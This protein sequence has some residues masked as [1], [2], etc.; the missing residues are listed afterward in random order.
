MLRQ[1]VAAAGARS[2]LRLQLR[3]KSTAQSSVNLQEK[4]VTLCRHRGFVFPGSDIYGGLANSFDYGPLGVQMKKNIQDAWWKHFVQSRTDC[5]GLD[6][7]VILSS[8]VWEASGHIGNFTDPMTVCKGC[9]SR[10]RADKL[11]ENA[12]DV[13]GVK[14]AGGLSCEE[15]DALIAE[16]KI[17]CPTCGSPD[18]QKTRQFNL[19]F[20][21]NMG[22]TDETSEWVYLRPET[23]QGAYINFQHVVTT[24][25]RRLPFGVGQMGKSF[26]NEISPGHYLFRTRE[27]E[28]LELQYF[29]HPTESDTWFSYWV[30]ECFNWL[31]KHGVKESNLKKR[32]HDQAELAH[33]AR[34][35]TD[36][37]FLYPFGWSELWGIA[38]RTNYDLRKHMEASGKDFNY[39]DPT[40][41]ETVLPH[42]VEPALGTGRVML[43][44]LLDAYD[45]EEVNGRP[46]TVLRLHPDIAPYKYAV[47]PLQSKGV[48]A[49]K[50]Q[51]IYVKLTKVASCDFDVTQSIGKRY[52]RQDEIG[53]PYCI[54]VDF[55]TLEDGTV[56]V[57]DRDSM[58][59]VRIPIDTLLSGQWQWTS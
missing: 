52:R 36:I 23:A 19:L 30:D 21:T 14:D 20:R 12:S 9:N 41:K 43:A 55:D 56:T 3:Q 1:K 25:R 24:M 29:C 49:E 31:I 35:T 26:R 27:F 15:I 34:A 11:I 53:T 47:L 57:R 37:E 39:V 22:S 51:E 28:Q 48:L 50:A 18:L 8:R 44:M 58:E 33:Y 2:A 38:N 32:I 5:V 59:Q 17:A 10:S 7:S 16:H 40:T 45:E 54:T 46:R 42:V 4:V 13:T 6:S